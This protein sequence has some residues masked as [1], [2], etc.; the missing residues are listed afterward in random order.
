MKKRIPIIPVQEHKTLF[1]RLK[2]TP[3][4]Q[5]F[6]KT[7]LVKGVFAILREVRFHLTFRSFDHG[8]EFH[9]YIC[10]LPFE[11]AELTSSGDIAVCCYLPKNLGNVNRRPFRKVWNSYFARK[12]RAS[13]LDGSFRYCDKSLCRSMQSFDANLIQVDQL[14]DA[15]L[16]EI[17]NGMKVSIEGSLKTLSLGNDFTCNLECP[18][19]RT[20]MRKMNKDEVKE[21]WDRY[22][23]IMATVGEE[24]EMIHIAG[25]GDAF[26]SQFYDQVI[27]KTEWDRFP[28]L[29]IGFQ[30]NGIA[31]TEK[32]WNGLPENVRS[33]VAYVGISID[34]ATA[35]TYEKL[36]LGGKFDSLMKNIAFLATMPDKR[37]YGF[38]LNLN[39]IVQAQNYHEIV[40][41][42][43]LGK[44]YGVDSVSFTYIRDWGTF[45]AGEYARHA[46]HLPAHPEHGR[47]LEILKS[48]VLSEPL[49]DR[50]NLLH[51]S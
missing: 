44:S 12:L 24:L 9:G 33:R 29:K 21:Q 11:Y 38:P 14:E 49:V 32:K 36:R 42:V 17:V 19:C 51:L 1:Q 25:D 22:T 18:S 2:K 27:R 31:L 20:G 13:M 37:T 34:G 4:A 50:G 35:P 47:L 41:L 3:L 30:T 40:S 26:S 46:V 5:N 28:N 8:K 23:E 10:R 7:G 6:K 48:P 43:E 45:P 16:K 15:R 39:M